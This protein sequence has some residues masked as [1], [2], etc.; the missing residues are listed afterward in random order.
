[1]KKFKIISSFVFLSSCLTQ[2]HLLASWYEQKLEGWYYFEDPTSESKKEE[3]DKKDLTPDSAEELIEIKKAELKKLLA[4]ALVDP[5]VQNVETYI[6]EQKKWIDQS[7][8]FAITWGKVLLNNPLLNDNLETPTSNYGIAVKREFDLQK[9]KN[10][11]KSMSKDWFLLFFFKSS[12][13]SSEKLAEVLQLFSDVNEWKTRAVSIDGK[14]VKGLNDF[15]IDK[16]ISLQFG[17][18]ATPSF[19]IVNPTLKVAY[20]VGA[21]LISVTEI[22]Q[23]IEQQV[24]SLHE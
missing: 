6:K 16:G 7:S 15:E 13:Y 4:L 3:I 24:G 23:N 17:L 2:S 18:K 8:L 19:F 14:S 22:E 20:P 9:R 21:G 10:L 11:I 5:S 1:M 12:D